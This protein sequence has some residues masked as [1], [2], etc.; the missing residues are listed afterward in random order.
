MDNQTSNIPQQ[1]VQQPVTQPAVAPVE[2]DGTHTYRALV[3]LHRTMAL[4]CTQCIAL[5]WHSNA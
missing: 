5:P 1:A 2:N 4:V 3:S